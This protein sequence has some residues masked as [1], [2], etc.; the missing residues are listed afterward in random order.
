[1]TKRVTRDVT[2]TCEWYWATAPQNEDGTIG[3]PCIWGTKRKHCAPDNGE[4]VVRVLVI[5]D[6]QKAKAP[7]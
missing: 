4:V 2:A 5:A 6:A 1:M 3:Q 7:R